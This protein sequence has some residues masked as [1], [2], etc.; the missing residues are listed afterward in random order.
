M[1]PQRDTYTPRWRCLMLWVRCRCHG[2]RMDARCRTSLLPPTTRKAIV[3]ILYT[4]PPL[5]PSPDPSTPPPL[6]P[7]PSPPT[8]TQSRYPPL[9]PSLRSFVGRLLLLFLLMSYA[10]SLQVVW[11]SL[12]VICLLFCD[13]HLEG[14]SGGVRLLL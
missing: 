11:A 5:L 3:I 4:Y 8:H 6:P 9:F 2:N 13:W 10:Q 7:P 12:E 1:L 14:R